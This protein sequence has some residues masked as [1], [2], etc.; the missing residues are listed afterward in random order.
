MDPGVS[1]QSV[2]VL[3]ATTV[4]AVAL[5]RR[6]RLPPMVGYLVTGLALGPHALGLASNAEE[7]Q[8]LAEF[9]IVFLMFSVGL[10]F[11]R[12]KL[13]ALRR[14]VF[15]LGLAQVL[16]TA[17]VAIGLALAC[18]AS[19]QAGAALGG[20]A[21]MSSTAIVSKL[22]SE[23]GELETAHGR[24][25]F[26]VLLF[27]DLA[28]VPLLVLVPALGQP[29]GGL[30]AALAA[31][32]AKAT[33]ALALV[34]LAGPPVLRGW[35]GVVARLRSSELFVLNVL[36]VTLLAAFLTGLAGLSLVL[37]AFLAGMLISET[38]YRYQVEQDIQPF[39]D[40]LLGLFFV[41]VGMMLDLR[42]VFGEWPL[43]LGLL[44]LL[45]VAKGALASALARL[46]GD[47]AGTALRVGLALAQAGEFGFVL[48]PLAGGLV[49]QALLQALLAAMILSMLATPFLIAASDRIV[50]RLS[51]S[52]WLLRSLELHRVAAQ[53][54]EAERHVIILGYG[55]N[56][57]RLARLLEAERVRYIALDLDPRRVREAAAAGDTVVFA[58]SARREA[59][60]AAGLARAAA[61]VVTFADAGAALRVLA[62]IHQLNPGVPVIVRAHDEADIGRLTEAGATEVVPEALESGLMLASHTL[63]MVGVPLSRVMRRV[64]QVRD[65][66]YALLR[67]LF[68]GAPDEREDERGVRLHAV[69]LEAG[70]RAVGET[71]ARL[72]LEGVGVQVRAVRRP[73]ERRKLDAPQAGELRAGDVV[74]LLGPPDALDRAEAR[75]LRG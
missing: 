29:A 51:R 65:G 20:I 40:V 46:F 10:E 48:L 2:L 3:L 39:R 8:R 41:T 22:L 72:A 37:G 24:H 63:V 57:Q 61:V 75:L 43:V 38:E 47:P 4:L 17:L 28:V 74:V 50:L 35:L 19:W 45:V 68:P 56:G 6:L 36:L 66:H 26:G 16:A 67:G 33:L 32:L 5:C 25:V 53:A 15:G 64:S 23:R 55:R 13:L 34:V 44:A 73:G 21:A 30:G 70:S 71:L 7:T 69:T 62:H 14:V 12:S 52:E 11:S 9:G 31:A 60:I 54:M 49:P 1:L 59:L 58:D 18:G 27:Q 42:L